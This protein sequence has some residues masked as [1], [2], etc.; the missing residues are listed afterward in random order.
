MP[1]YV[2]SYITKSEHFSCPQNKNMWFYLT[3]ILFHLHFSVTLGLK[4]RHFCCLCIILFSFEV[5][6]EQWNLVVKL[7]LTSTRDPAQA[8]SMAIANV[9]K[10]KLQLQFKLHPQFWM[11]ILFLDKLT[12]WIETTFSF[13]KG[14][15]C[16]QFLL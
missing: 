13:S 14:D 16:T 7:V 12:L 5:I 10:S 9:F 6:L 3:F 1:F 15:R 4:R 11:K 2:A 8:I